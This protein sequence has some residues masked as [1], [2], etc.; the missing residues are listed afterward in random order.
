MI[1]IIPAIDIINGEC[2]RLKQG[3]FSQKT[4]YGLDPVDVAKEFESYGAKKL[5]IVDLDAAKT[6]RQKNIETIKRVALSTNL[7]IDVGGGI[8]TTAQVENLLNS[9]IGAVNIGS[10]ALT[11]PELF[12]NWLNWFGRDRIWLSADVRKEHISINGWQ[13]QTNTNIVKLLKEFTQCGLKTAVITAIERDGMMKGP[14]IKLYE[15][16]NSLFPGLTIVASGGVSARVDLMELDQ[17]GI[18]KAIV[19]KALYETSQESLNL[20]TWMKNL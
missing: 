5:H 13:K 20:K 15:K 9:D 4:T 1:E 2:V 12:K 3:D 6:G 11:Q 17:I 18:S 8:K 19:G 7:T 16:I 10:T 14:D